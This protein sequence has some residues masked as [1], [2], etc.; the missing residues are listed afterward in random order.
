MSILI[1]SLLSLPLL[2]PSVQ[3]VN[4]FLV[5]LLELCF[6]ALILDVLESVH[7]ELRHGCLLGL[8]VGVTCRILESV[9]GHLPLLGELYVVLVKDYLLNI[10]GWHLSHEER[11]HVALFETLEYLIFKAQEL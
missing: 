8:V 11:L 3:E 7:L 10:M 1:R 2:D 9:L 5:L 6:D 4:S